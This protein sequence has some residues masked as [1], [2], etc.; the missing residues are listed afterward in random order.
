MLLNLLSHYFN[1]VAVCKEF[2]SQLGVVDFGKMASLIMH[3]SKRHMTS[4]TLHM[5]GVWLE[6]V[7][8]VTVASDQM[9]GCWDLRILYPRPRG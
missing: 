1:E 9:A 4:F 2:N 7:L 5:C 3:Q 6:N 8:E